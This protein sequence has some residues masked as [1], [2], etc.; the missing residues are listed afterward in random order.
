MKNLQLEI[1]IKAFGIAM[2]LLSLAYFV[3]YVKCN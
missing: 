2:F 1:A 3:L